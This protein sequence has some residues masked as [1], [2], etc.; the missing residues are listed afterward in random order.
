MSK[1]TTFFRRIFTS[2]TSD[3][4][5]PTSSDSRRSVVLIPPASSPSQTKVFPPQTSYSCSPSP[6][7]TTRVMIKQTTIQIDH[8][9]DNHSP[10]NSSSYPR[11]INNRRLS[12]PMIIHASTIHPFRQQR[13]PVVSETT[14]EEL[15]SPLQRLSLSSINY[16]NSVHSLGQSGSCSASA[17]PRNDAHLSPSNSI[18]ISNFSPT[19]GRYN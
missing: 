14:E 10:T 3:D 1:L 17:S 18:N 15:I 7:S 6:R 13:S 9:N 16:N 2:L 8:I 11:K 12:A 19:T 5:S 4:D